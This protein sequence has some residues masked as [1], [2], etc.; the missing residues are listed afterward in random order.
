MMFI[1]SLFTGGADEGYQTAE[2]HR[3]FPYKHSILMSGKAPGVLSPFF[4]L[5]KEVQDH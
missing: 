3:K 2:V 4:S 1:Y 5:P